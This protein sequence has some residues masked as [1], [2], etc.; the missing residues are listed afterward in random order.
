MLIFELL[1]VVVGFIS[2]NHNLSTESLEMPKKVTVESF[3]QSDELNGENG[4]VKR[5]SNWNPCVIGFNYN[6]TKDYGLYQINTINWHSW[7]VNPDSYVVNGEFTMSVEMQNTYCRKYVK[8]LIDFMNNTH[9]EV[10]HKR[11]AMGW[12]GLYN[13][14]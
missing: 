7:G 3:M 13:I 2:H 11:I 1:L 12:Y 14:K 10:T 6:G 5:E 8:Q 9:I 4:I